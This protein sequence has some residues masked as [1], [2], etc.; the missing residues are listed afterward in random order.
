MTGMA[1]RTL[2]GDVWK[3]Y[4]ELFT[5]RAVE[6]HFLDLFHEGKLPGTVAHLHRPGSP[7]L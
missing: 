6:Q 1:N 5:I 2:P 3:T 4:E 7:A